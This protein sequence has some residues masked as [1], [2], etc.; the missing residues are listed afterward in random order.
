MIP[1]SKLMKEVEQRGLTGYANNTRWD[2]FLRSA[3]DMP[4]RCRVKPVLRSEPT[5]WSPWLLP[6][7][8]YL[9]LTSAGIFVFRDIEWIELDAN[10]PRRE[11]NAG[12]A[13]SECFDLLIEQATSERLTTSDVGD[14]I[15]RV[16]GYR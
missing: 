6:A 8:G 4:L 11:P 16:W 1:P 15:V 3:V 7:P 12:L 14:R 5:S 2:S 13:A 10:T 9:E